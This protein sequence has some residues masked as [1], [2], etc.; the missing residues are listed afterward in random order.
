MKQ[1][2][3]LLEPLIWGPFVTG[4]FLTP[5]ILPAVIFSLGI[6]A[7]LGWLP[8]E[9]LSYEVEDRGVHVL[10]VCPGVI[11]TPFFGE[12]DLAVMPEVAKQ[13]MVPVDGLVDAV[14]K[15]LRR[16]RREVTH[17]APIAAAYRVR[18]LAPGLFRWGVRRTTR[19]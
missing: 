15:A 19:R 7:P 13:G 8:G 9:A 12:D 1:L 5:L 14:M 10:A 18:A 2:L 4:N 11:D 3:H 16:G 6:A 17:P